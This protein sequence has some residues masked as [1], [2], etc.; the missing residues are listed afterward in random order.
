MTDIDF[1]KDM[2]PDEVAA[3]KEAGALAAK[4]L[5]GHS[6]LEGL[7]IGDVLLRGRQLVCDRYGVQPR[8]QP[9]GNLFAAWKAQFG[10]P[11]FN[12]PDQRRHADAFFDEAIFCARHRDLANEIISGE[13]PKWRANSGVSAVTKR[14]R[15]KLRERE[16][17]LPK[18]LRP[19]TV[20]VLKARLKDAEGELADA[21]DRLANTDGGSLFDLARTDP[22]SIA[23]I[24]I[25]N[26]GLARTRNI[27]N[28]LTQVIDAA[29]RKAH[30]KS[31]QAG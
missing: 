23:R 17:Q 13:S 5:H 15:A 29:E 4:H 12:D 6:L 7:K 1:T 21:K 14:I 25:E 2:T 31:K 28:A 27:R 30:E 9:Y 26:V 19:S 8:G 22:K 20:A 10:F 18:T 11:I 24:A 16:G 3:A